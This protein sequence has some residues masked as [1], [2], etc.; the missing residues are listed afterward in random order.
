[1]VIKKIMSL[2]PN[3]DLNKIQI[4]LDIGI[5]LIKEY[6]NTYD[7]RVNIEL[8]YEN[9]LV[10]FLINTLDYSKDKGIVTKKQGNKSITY[11]ETRKALQLTSDIKDLLPC[12]KVKLMG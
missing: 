7:S 3:E 9:A 1:M 10:L 8:K 6:L 12:P 11:S 2:Y 5:N 4:Y